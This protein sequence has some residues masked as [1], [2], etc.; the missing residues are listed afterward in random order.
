MRMKS[1]ERR[2][3]IIDVAAAIFNE[4]GFERTS[5]SEI[6]A[7]LGG[8]KATLYNYFSSKEDIFVETMRQQIGQHYEAV[9]EQLVEGGDLRQ[10]LQQVGAQYLKVILMPEVVAVK[11]L[12]LAHAERWNIG[13]MLYERG[14]KPGWTR[15]SDFL[16]KAM[17]RQ[18]LRVADPWVAA[19][20]LRGLL[21]TEWME[22]RMLGVITGATPAKIKESAERAID[23]FMR[24]YTPE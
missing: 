14:P 24:I 10:T 20:Q 5:M 9:F 19:L 11:R 21:E 12:V 6:S 15:V 22:T 2:Q 16:R 23:A 18:Q 8:S 3:A 4:I 17:E 7:R 1:E 13:K